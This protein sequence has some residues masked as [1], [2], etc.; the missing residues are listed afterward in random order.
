MKKRLEDQAG[1]ALRVQNKQLSQAKAAL[2]ELAAHTDALKDSQ[3]NTM[4]M[5]EHLLEES[6]RTRADRHILFEISEPDEV[7]ARI[8]PSAE[9]LSV[10]ERNLPKLMPLEVIDPA[11]NWAD[12]CEQANAYAS[13]YKLDLTADPLLQLL[14]ETQIAELERKYNRLFGTLKWTSWDY[15]AVTLIALVAILT[16]Y[17]IV[18]IPSTVN[19][20]GV[21]YEG[22]DATAWLRKQSDRIVNSGSNDGAY[23]WLNQGRKWLEEQAKVPYDAQNSRSL[24]Q[25]VPGLGPHHHRLM[26]LGHDPILG[27]VF[28]VMDILRGTMTVIDGKGMFRVV[29]RSADYAPSFNIIGA[30]CKVFA[31]LLSDIPTS[32]GIQPPFFSVLQCLAGKSPFIL[33]PSGEKVTWTD[34]ARYMYKHGYTMEHFLTMSIVPMI[35][36]LGVRIYYK[37]ANFE[38]A[39]GDDAQMIVKKDAKLASML[40]LGHSLTMSGNILKTGLFGWNPAALNWSEL[41]MLFESFFALYS[42]RR[43]RDQAIDKYLSHNWEVLYQNSGAFRS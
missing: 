13:K 15:G 9:E 5:A 36:E 1:T 16:D 35:V 31:H 34:A 23:S 8:N 21:H 11:D 18:A 26:T 42:A 14:T 38:T 17:F 30:F 43:E 40:T 29:D 19:F 3:A 27:F 41:L 25:Y 4:K 24:D 6:E 33:G 10:I 39:Y 12:Y 28:G 2:S 7:I 37:I 32:A 20:R 22:S